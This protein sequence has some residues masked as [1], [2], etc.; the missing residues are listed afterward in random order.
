MLKLSKHFISSDRR[1]FTLIELLV[2][3]GM[4]SI[5]T[6]VALPAFAMMQKNVSLKNYTKEIVSNLRQA[7]TQAITSQNGS[8]HGIY[9]SND[10]YIICEKDCTPAFR[11][12]AYTIANGVSILQGAGASV[13]FN[14]LTGN[15]TPQ[16]IVIGF[17]GGKQNTITVDESGLITTTY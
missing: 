10:Q 1:A 9:F 15:T 8:S 4:I 17:S 7:Q 2:V 13:V 16:T 5:V 14:R 12:T 11:T 3:I 6:A